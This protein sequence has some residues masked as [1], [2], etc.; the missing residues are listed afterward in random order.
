[1]SETPLQSS[2][3]VS[4]VRANEQRVAQNMIDALLEGIR[5]VATEAVTFM[6]YDAHPNPEVADRVEKHLE[7]L[8][9]KVRSYSRSLGP[10]PQVVLIVSWSK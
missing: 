9:Y 4:L 5:K 2:E 6:T 1:M 8:G 10:E 3:A 7:S